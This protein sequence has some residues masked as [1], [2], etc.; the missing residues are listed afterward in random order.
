[1][2]FIICQCRK[3][4]AALSPIMLCLVRASKDIP[5]VWNVH[6]LQKSHF[7]HLPTSA[8]SIKA[9]K[10]N[11]TERCGVDTD[12]SVLFISNAIKISSTIMRVV[13]L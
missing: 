9:G 8:R 4:V 10:K 11:Q 5:L 6:I 2:G 13:V 1:M 7:E 3:I 12:M